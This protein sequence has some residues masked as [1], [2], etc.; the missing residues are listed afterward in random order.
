MSRSLP[1]NPA[2]ETLK[3]QA[4]SLLKSRNEQD[5]GTSLGLQECQHALAKDYGFRS[6]AEMKKHVEGKAGEGKYLHIHCGDSSA[7][8]LRESSVGGDVFVWR[9]IYIEGPAPGNL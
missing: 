7:D 6:W 4:K 3:K 5:P 2:L 1:E 9:E 8:S